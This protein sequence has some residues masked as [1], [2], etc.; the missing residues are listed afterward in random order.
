MQ[1]VAGAYMY[2]HVSPRVFS[3]DKPLKSYQFCSMWNIFM[4]L[5]HAFSV[6]LSNSSIVF[7]KMKKK[8]TVCHTP[9]EALPFYGVSYVGILCYQYNL[10]L[11]AFCQYLHVV[12]FR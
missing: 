2:F 12:Q 3:L 6:V 5:V 7:C 8:G 1:Y 4:L 9:D 10:M 11:A